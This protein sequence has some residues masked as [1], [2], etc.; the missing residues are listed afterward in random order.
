MFMCKLLSKITLTLL[1]VLSVAVCGAGP[2]VLNLVPSTAELVVVSGKLSDL[3]S[4]LGDIVQKFGLPEE[5]SIDTIVGE[6]SDDIGL[7]EGLALDK[8]RPFCFAMTSFMAGEKALLVYLPVNDPQSVIEASGSEKLESGLYKFDYDG[9]MT[10]KGNYLMVAS[11]EANLKMAAASS[12]GM[13]VPDVVASDMS[14]SDISV[15]A[16]LTNVM[17]M[18][19]SMVPLGLASVPELQSQPELVGKI[20]EI[21][22]SVTEINKLSLAIDVEDGGFKTTANMFYMPGGSLSNALKPYKQT[23]IDDLAAMPDG[24]L[25]TMTSVSL[26]PAVLKDMYSFILNI[27]AMA[28]QGKIDGLDEFLTDINVTIAEMFDK[29]SDKIG[30]HVQGEYITTTEGIAP[31]AAAMTL[32]KTELDKKSVDDMISNFADKKFQSFFEVNT[33]EPEAGKVDG[34]TYSNLKYTI[35]QPLPTGNGEVFKTEVDLYFGQSKSG[36]YVQTMD[37][38]AL[39]EAITLSRSEKTLKGN[40]GFM[41]V[42]GKMPDS[43]NIYFIADI[44]NMFDYVGAAM[45][46]QT[47]EMAKQDPAMA[48]QAAM[49]GP[50]METLSSSVKGYGASAVVLEDGYVRETCYVSME[51]VETFVDAVKSIAQSFMGM[52]MGGSNGSA[53]EF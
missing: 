16:N 12:A 27:V 10:A 22:N 3:D 52:Q 40:D 18:A 35:G 41:K 19:K 34:V 14:S 49:M 38:A 11:N 8:S 45:N 13:S 33:F 28:T 25:M 17:I 5:V 9:F 23:S 1:M 50:V 37:K 4:K 53:T 39:S 24:N 42:A 51:T 47:Q 2:D 48:M 36:M 43:A 15:Y 7:S 6:L 26:D 30:T 31:E 44:S 32:T 46:A 21:I 20:Q 29:Y